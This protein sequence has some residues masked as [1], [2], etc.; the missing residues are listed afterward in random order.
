M[1]DSWY[2][3]RFFVPSFEIMM[4]GEG[5]KQKKFSFTTGYEDPTK[6]NW[7]SLCVGRRTDTFWP[8]DLT[9]AQ[10]VYKLYCE[11]GESFKQ[12]AGGGNKS[13]NYF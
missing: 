2:S 5:C 3:M 8:D 12:K 9:C 4:R 7:L 13:N 10:Y 6:E 11:T 1:K